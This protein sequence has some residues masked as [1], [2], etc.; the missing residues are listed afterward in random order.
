MSGLSTVEQSLGTSIGRIASILSSERFPT[1]DRAALRRITPGETPSLAFYRFA[2]EYL[3][4]NWDATAGSRKDWMTLVAGMAVMSPDAYRP[5]RRFGT[6][7]AEGGYAESRLERLLSAKDDA[8]R[9][10]FLRA[11][12]FLRAKTL[13]FN[14]VDAARLL[15]TRDVEKREAVHRQI[16][17]NFFAHTKS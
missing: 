15:L 2:F 1:G 9:I 14:W 17:R 7:L 16:A 6:A 8:R 11:V 13:P 12:R 5:D 3:P 10:L 4:D